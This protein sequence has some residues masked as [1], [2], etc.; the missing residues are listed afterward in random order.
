MKKFYLLLTMLCMAFV[1]AQTPILTAV[2]DGDCPGGTPKMVEIYAYGTVD[3]S[4]YNIEKQSNGGAW[5]DTTSLAEFGTVTDGFVYIYSDSSDPEIFAQEFPGATTSMENS[6][7]NINGDDGLRLVLASDGTVVDQFGADGVDGTGTGWEYADGYAKRNNGSG[8]DSPFLE[9]NWT[10]G[11]GLLDGEGICQGGSSFQDVMGGIGTYSPEGGSTE[12]SLGIIY[13]ANGSVLPLGTTSV[14]LEFAVNN[15]N[16]GEAG[17]ASDGHVHYTVDGGSVNMHFSTDP[18]QI[19]GLTP[20]E[21]TIMLWLVDNAHQPLD[22]EVT[23][24][25]VFSIPGASSVATIAELRAGAT[26]GSVYTFTGQGI[27]TMY[28]NYRN[29]I[30][31]QDGTAAIL[32]DDPDNIIATEY[33]RGD[34]MT[35]VAGTLTN[36]NG[37]LQLRPTTDPG[38]PA[39]SG[40]TIDPQVVTIADFNANPEMYESELIKVEFVSTEATG[41]WATGTNY[42][43]MNGTDTV[44]VRTNF[45]NAD[46]IGTALPAGQ[47]HLVGIASEYNGAAQLYPRDSNDI[48]GNLAV[49]DINVNG[50]LVK[51][52]VQNNVLHISGFD[53]QNITIYNVNGQIVA[54]SAF[55]GKLKSGTYIAVMKNAEG[56]MVSVKFIRK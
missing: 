34:A 53:A 23:V 28:Q 31:I 50:A 25:T 55:V 19:T 27:V 10:Y 3:F 20:G 37:V 1:T 33:V 14:S 22:P 47:V 11:N 2:A 35:N 21:H 39:S 26:D 29:Q 54:D 44:L 13:P 42:D 15:F 49:N 41:N 7:V 56:Q 4:L 32:I 46:Y 30:W 52:A 17:S 43:F 24:S 6:V 9:S 45:F 51:V 40:N 16:I 8:P 5:G 48:I 38:A 36:F 18:I 12:P